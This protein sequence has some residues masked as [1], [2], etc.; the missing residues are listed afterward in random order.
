MLSENAIFQF[1][2]LGLTVSNYF[3][4]ERSAERPVSSSNEKSARK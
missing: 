2:A 4:V 1:L 3:W